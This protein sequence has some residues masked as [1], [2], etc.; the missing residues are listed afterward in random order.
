[1]CQVFILGNLGCQNSFQLY[2][3]S[4]F[5]FRETMSLLDANPTRIVPCREVC[6][7]NAFKI[8]TSLIMTRAT[9][10]GQLA[11]EAKCK[12]AFKVACPLE[13]PIPRS[14]GEC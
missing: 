8:A 7:I 2:L 14:S 9:L 10:P 3:F 1:M 12:N 4:H 5:Y 13:C 11:A 6:D